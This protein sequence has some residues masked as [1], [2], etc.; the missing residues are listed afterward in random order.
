[1]DSEDMSIFLQ[2]VY[3]EGFNAAVKNT[4]SIT[5]EDIHT[6]I[7]SVKG[8]GEKRMI[9]IDESIKTLFKKKGFNV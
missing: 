9:E 1:M 2:N 4:N 7:S 8:I 5:L 3:Q 6:S